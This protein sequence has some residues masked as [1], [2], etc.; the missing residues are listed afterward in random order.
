[1]ME[2]GR[3]IKKKAKEYFIL[4]MVISMNDED[5]DYKLIY[6]RYNGEWKNDKKEGK[7]IIFYFASSNKYE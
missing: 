4:Q 6:F 3:M 5:I 7:G 1:M 2:N